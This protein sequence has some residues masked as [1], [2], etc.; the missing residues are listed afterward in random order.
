MSKPIYDINAEWYDPFESKEERRSAARVAAELQA[1]ITVRA[2]EK[3]GRMIGPALGEDISLTGMRTVTKHQLIPGQSVKLRIATD[4][5]EVPEVMAREFETE[6]QVL[7][8]RPLGRRHNQVV[9]RFSVSLTNDMDFALFVQ[10][11]H[12]RSAERLAS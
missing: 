9:L 3:R 1:E 11:M 10:A 5:I 4:G 2:T 12:S 8:V 6:C 7:R